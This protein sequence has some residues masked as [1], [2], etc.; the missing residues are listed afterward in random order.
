MVLYVCNY[1]L[2]F[3]K[4]CHI[5]LVA[6]LLCCDGAFIQWALLLIS[7]CLHFIL[8]Y[9]DIWNWGLINF[10]CC[11]EDL[12]TSHGWGKRQ[13]HDQAQL[14][15]NILVIAVEGHLFVWMIYNIGF[16]MLTNVCYVLLLCVLCIYRVCSG[17]A[18]KCF[19]L[20]V[21]ASQIKLQLHACCLQNL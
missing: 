6:C 15:Q 11:I 1:W 2:A 13:P 17:K 21:S 9:R 10:Y 16:K 12:F 3:Q 18:N 5:T 20:Q 7:K 19:C 14:S 8:G 4:T